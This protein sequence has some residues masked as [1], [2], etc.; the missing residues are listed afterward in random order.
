MGVSQQRR[1]RIWRAMP[2]SVQ[3]ALGSR[4]RTD[5]ERVARTRTVEPARRTRGA[6][7]A[8][9]AR[10]RPGRRL[11]RNPAYG[12]LATVGWEMG[13]SSRKWL[14]LTQPAAPYSTLNGNGQCEGA[15]EEELFNAGQEL[16]GSLEPPLRLA[17]ESYAAIVPGC[18]GSGMANTVDQATLGGFCPR[19]WSPTSTFSGVWTL[20][21]HRDPYATCYDADGT[22]TVDTPRIC[23][24]HVAVS[25]RAPRRRLRA[26]RRHRISRV[27]QP[28]TGQKR[29]DYTDA[30]RRRPSRIPRKLG[31]RRSH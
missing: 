28:G 8:L 3:C 29:T 9:G 12:A 26:V 1:D 31:L 11:A 17:T 22:A 25:V 6:L 23:D 20:E 5:G 4:A 15:I 14:E 10:K 27:Q 2:R 21:L 30:A 16:A 13:S 19:T 7:P 18:P 24:G